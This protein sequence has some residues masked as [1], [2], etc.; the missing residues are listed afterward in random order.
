[1]DRARAERLSTLFL[2]VFSTGLAARFAADGLA[3]GQWP[4]ALAAVLGSLAV[5]AVVRIWPRPQPV[6]SR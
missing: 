3:P 2:A 4:G 5:A 1:M 6:R